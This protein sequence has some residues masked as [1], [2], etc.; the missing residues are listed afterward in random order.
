M[1]L[2]SGPVGSGKTTAVAQWVRSAGSDVVWLSLDSRDDGPDR[3]RTRLLAHW[4]AHNASAETTGWVAG[5]G[6]LERP[7]VVVCDGVEDITDPVAT[8][9]LDEL[10][11]DGPRWLHVVL[12][13]RSMP[14]LPSLTRLRLN[15]ELQE[16]TSTD[17]RC[18][19]EE[20]A[21]VLAALGIASD[22]AQR[23]LLME[24]TEGLI[25]AV[26]LSGVLESNRRTS[27]GGLSGETP[28]LAQYLYSEVVCA[29]TVDVFGFMLATSVFDE[30]EP[31]ACDEITG[32]TDSSQLL[33]DLARRNVLTEALDSGRY[34]YH[35]LF[36]GFL[37]AELRRTRPDRWNALHRSAAA[38]YERRGNEDR[39]LHHWVEAGEIEEA[40]SRF[41]RRA[42]PRFFDGAVT[43]VAQWTEM[44]PRP[45]VAI[46]VG[47]A[48]DMA[49]TL[50]YMG[51]VEGGRDWSQ[52]VDSGFVAGG[53]GNG[54][55][56]ADTIARRAYLQFLLDFAQG[57]LVKAAR[58][59]K[60][61]RE[62]LDRSEWSWDELRAPCAQAQLQS[63][64]G[65]PARARAT[66]LEF[67][68]RA[69]PRHATDRVA[70]PGV[71]GEIALAE[72]RLA[73]AE[74]FSNDALDASGNV[75]DPEFWFTITPR[76]VRGVVHLE[77]NRLDAARNDLERACALGAKQGYV[78]AA[79]L[80]MLALARVQHIAGEQGVAADLLQQ[81]RRRLRRRDAL[82]LLQRV[83]ETEAL[84]AIQSGDLDHATALVERL[85]DPSRSR[86]LARLRAA[87][88]TTKVR[89][90][91]STTSQTSACAITSTCSCSGRAVRATATWRTSCVRRSPSAKRT[92]TSGCSSTRR[93]GSRRRCAASSA[94]G[95]LGT[96]P[97][98]RPR[99]SRSRIDAHRRGT[100]PS[101]RIANRRYGA[102]CRPHCRC[103]RSL[104]RSMY[105][106]TR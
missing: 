38:F 69:D 22:P 34:R 60:R 87:A 16:I 30:L 72:G 96:R 71:F 17:L 40:W 25:A 105:R 19:D 82:P 26:A 95:P 55:G 57:D 52:L 73:E 85:H 102:S 86:V 43:A 9:D 8:G 61:A 44:L 74:A 76:Y 99:S 56:D 62:L 100:S 20:A 31:E 3:L 78:H 47:Q 54:E 2:V 15:G 92:G 36:R 90:R 68:A 91:S 5:L 48:L 66:L 80:P 70:V 10:C 41:R 32:R 18:D 64:M 1:T 59:G 104:T 49:L 4:P 29:L 45:N 28:E 27:F 24:R 101:C 93:N 89:T 37:R 39:A 65:R 88:R 84:F 67:V 63:L 83:D 35:R 75:A 46:D 97:R 53:D 103:R 21:D 51:D 58:Q 50:T 106:A 11:L 98:S 13:G 42:L 14:P 94:A 12:V 77:R 7:T 81:A 23:A 79:L 6:D 33:A